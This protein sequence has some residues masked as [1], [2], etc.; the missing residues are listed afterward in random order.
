MQS[1]NKNVRLQFPSRYRRYCEAKR[2]ITKECSGEIFSL[3]EGDRLYSDSEDEKRPRQRVR[4][5]PALPEFASRR[6]ETKNNIKVVGTLDEGTWAKR[7]ESS[8]RIYGMDGIAPTIPT[9]TGGGIM[10]KI[11]VQP[12]LTPD[13]PNKRQNGRRIKEDGEPSFTLTA[14]DKHGILKD[15]RIRRLTP[16]EC[17]RLQGFPDTWCDIGA[18]GKEISDSQIYK[19]AGNAVTTNVVKAI[20]EKLL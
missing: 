13:R 20:M 15:S 4:P 19:M 7:N 5:D 8:R 1:K 18:D 16:V 17:M 11:S 3:G 6:R 14:Q 12:V 10:P 9:G 2:R